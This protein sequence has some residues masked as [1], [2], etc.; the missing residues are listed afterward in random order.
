[1]N[2]LFLVYLAIPAFLANMA[3]IIANKLNWFSALDKPIDFNKKIFDK[4]L[5]GE[6]KTFRGL[7][8]GVIFSTLTTLLQF[9]LN[10]YNVINF[11]IFNS[12]LLTLSFGVLT[13]AGVII[14][15]MI[16]SSIKRQ[17][18]IKP[19]RPFFPFDQIDY[20]IGFIIFTYPI[21][22]WELNQII[23]LLIFS[24]IAHPLVNIIAYVFKIKK[25]YW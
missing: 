10:K 5:F 11:S 6:H 13:G 8:V 14:G 25:T 19:G 4:R 9:I 24:S 1:M 12:L 22:N 2:Y 18:N 21:I 15:D 7:V 17:I 20:I 16:E 3:P 23:F